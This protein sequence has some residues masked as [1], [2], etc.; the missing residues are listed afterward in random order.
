MTK[1]SIIISL[2]SLL[3]LFLLLGIGYVA[4]KKATTSQS[5]NDK[6]FYLVCT[7]PD[8]TTPLYFYMD[9]AQPFI[10]DRY[11]SVAEVTSW[12]AEKIEFK[13]TTPLVG[14]IVVVGDYIIHRVSGEIDAL[15]WA[16]NSKTD[17][18]VGKVEKSTGTCEKLY[19]PKI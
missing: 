16:L 7:S 19:A 9:E 3:L 2:I 17:E 8:L 11:N 14:D 13:T 12:G 6:P 5:T 10:R 15:Q 1:R 18:I 4:Y